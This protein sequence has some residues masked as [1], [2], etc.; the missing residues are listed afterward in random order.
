MLRIIRFVELHSVCFGNQKGRYS[1]SSTSNG[2]SP[3]LVKFVS[4][5][6]YSMRGVQAS[7]GYWVAIQYTYIINIS[8]IL[9]KWS[10]KYSLTSLQNVANVTTFGGEDVP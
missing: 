5:S 1:P 3:A 9:L 8:K 2:L 7:M 4:F 6:K 10:Q